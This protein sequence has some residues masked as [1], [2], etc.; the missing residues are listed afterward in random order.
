VK[1]ITHLH[2]VPMSRIRGAMLPLPNTHWWRGDQL[3]HRDGC[4]W[5]ASRPCRFIPGLRVP[6]TRLVEGGVG[7]SR[8]GRGSEEK[9]IL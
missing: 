2:L 6:G 1:L 7:L 3:K 4:E 8:Y 5:S 9:N